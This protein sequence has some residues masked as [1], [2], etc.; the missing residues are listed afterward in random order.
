MEEK[1]LVLLKPDAV[2][3]GLIGEI[4][5]RFEKVGFRLMGMK[6]VQADEDLGKQHY[7]DVGQRHGEVI[8]KGLVEFITSGPIVAMVIE[9]INAVAKVRQMVGGTY[10]QEALPG[11]IRGDLAH[12]SKDYAN[13][14]GIVVKNLVH[15]SS[16]SEEAKRELELWFQPSEMFDYE[17]VHHKHTRN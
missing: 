8:Q 15:A 10:P 9:G 16:S 12:V 6:L 7:F 3:R 13:E 4:I 14:R 17:P 5:S 11:T 2:E 1:T